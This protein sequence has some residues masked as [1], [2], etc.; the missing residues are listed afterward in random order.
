MLDDPLVPLDT[1]TRVLFVGD[2]ADLPALRRILADLPGD[3]YGQ[4]FIEIASRIQIEPLLVPDAVSVSWLRRDLRCSRIDGLAPRGALAARAL[5][6]WASEWMPDD[7]DSE[8]ADFALWV[9]CAT[10]PRVDAAFRRLHASLHE[11]DAH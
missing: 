11:R 9:G 3:A 8:G 2:S 10:S 5:T 6:A 4:V 1:A 7:V